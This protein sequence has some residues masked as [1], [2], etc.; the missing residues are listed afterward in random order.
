MRTFTNVNQSDNETR[1][2]NCQHYDCFLNFCTD[3]SGLIFFFRC[4]YI[5]CISTY[6]PTNKNIRITWEWH[7]YKVVRSLS[8]NATKTLV[9][10]FIS[11]RLDYCNSLL[12]GISDG[13]LQRLQSVQNATARLVTGARRS[14]HITPVLRQRL[15]SLSTYRCY[16]NKCIYLSI[17]LSIYLYSHA[18][19]TRWTSMANHWPVCLHW[20]GTFLNKWFLTTFGI[21]LTLT[22]DLQN[23]ISLSLFPTAP[24]L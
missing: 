13:L 12:Y 19:L 10:V 4:S 8:M 9:Q 23:I 5:R 15:V 6:I 1:A 22:F 2:K 24:K 17:Y 7:R 16:T 11:C 20:K 14:D 21:D 18:I 3:F